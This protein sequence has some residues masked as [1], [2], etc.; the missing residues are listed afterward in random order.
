MYISYLA[1][2]RLNVSPHGEGTI[3]QN[4]MN[5]TANGPDCLRGEGES[6]SRGQLVKT[7][8]SKRTRPYALD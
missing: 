4:A 6:I 3:A 8:K 1:S 2:E 7:M 5:V